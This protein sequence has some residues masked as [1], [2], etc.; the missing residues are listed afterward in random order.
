L[1][2]QLGTYPVHRLDV[3]LLHRLYRDKPH[4]RPAHCFT[5]R[6]GIVGVV[7]VTLHVRFYELWR[8]HPHLESVRLQSPRPVVRATTRFHANLAAR[9]SRLEQYLEPIRPRELSPPYRL[10]IAAYAVYL[11][12]VLCQIY[13]NP[14]KLHDG[15]LLP[16]DWWMTLPVW[17]LD[18][19]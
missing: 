6:L 19:D 17:H 5:D 4:M 2:G 16:V 8:D 11:K 7:L 1:L 10:L 14:N 15:L 13:P 18:A 12:D 9:F 3:L